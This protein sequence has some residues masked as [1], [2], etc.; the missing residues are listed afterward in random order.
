MKVDSLRVN[1]PAAIVT[2]SGGLGLPG[3]RPDS[4][5][6]SMDVDSLGG[7]RFLAHADSRRSPTTVVIVPDSI[8]GSLTLARGVAIGTM[9]TLTVRGTAKATGVYYNK[10]SAESATLDFN[11][12]DLPKSLA[13]SINL[14]AD[15]ATVAGVAAR[16][17]SRRAGLLR[18]HAR[19][20]RRR[21]GEPQR[22]NRDRDGR[23]GLGQRR[24]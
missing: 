12:H 23:L 14:H 4:L 1:S 22:T 10:Y 6:F 9:D 16:F 3:G 5:I 11:L 13:G 15:T 7:L 2:A 21:R 19:A 17:D 8:A 24:Q 20:F 18:S